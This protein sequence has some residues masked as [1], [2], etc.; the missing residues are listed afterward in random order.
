MGKR[1][2]SEYEMR[3]SEIPLS[4]WYGTRSNFEDGSDAIIPVSTTAGTELVRVVNLY[5]TMQYKFGAFQRYRRHIEFA[6]P[7]FLIRHY[8]NFT[9]PF[10]E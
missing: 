4:G 2:D 8:H 1:T 6:D 9:C 5:Y 7:I 10:R 3:A